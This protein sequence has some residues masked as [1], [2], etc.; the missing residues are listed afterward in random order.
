MTG[1]PRTLKIEEDG[2]RCKGRIKPKIRLC[3]KW[4]ERAGFKPGYFVSVTHIADG[5]LK[6]RSERNSELDEPGNPS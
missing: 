3:G 1:K 6:L 5:I 2:D 4:L